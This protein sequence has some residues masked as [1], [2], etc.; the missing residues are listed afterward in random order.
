M[1]YIRTAVDSDLRPCGWPLVVRPHGFDDACRRIAQRHRSPL[2]RTWRGAELSNL[3]GFGAGA[4]R[5]RQ[6]AD[7]CLTRLRHL[8]AMPSAAFDRDFAVRIKKDLT[9]HGCG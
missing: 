2:G 1:P 8:I 7:Q 9:N 6:H 3:G 4:D 5:S